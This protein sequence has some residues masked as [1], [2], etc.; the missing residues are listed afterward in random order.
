MCVR[1]NL[2]KT[3]PR[4]FMCVS[5]FFERSGTSVPMCVS[6]CCIQTFYWKAS[7]QS[8]PMFSD[9]TWCVVLWCCGFLFW[10]CR[11]IWN[12][13]HNVAAFVLL[14]LSQNI[15][16]H[17]KQY[18][19]ILHVCYGVSTRWRWHSALNIWRLPFLRLMRYMSV[20]Q[21]VCIAQ[22]FFRT[23][24]CSTGRQNWGANGGLGP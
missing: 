1:N 7:L 10:C 5:F 4:E 19:E 6:M 22:L 18:I 9:Y 12:M 24:Y 14:S 20:C 8:Q 3:S 2:L 17:T 15:D 16:C 13:K 21:Y 11:W 23:L